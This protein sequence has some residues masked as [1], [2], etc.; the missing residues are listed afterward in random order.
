MAL[1]G[2]WQGPELSCTARHPASCSET[3]TLPPAA[4]AH[5]S[6]GAAAADFLVLSERASVTSEM[7]L[8]SGELCGTGS[9]P[10]LALQTRY[11][12]ERLRREKAAEIDAI[13]TFK[14]R[15]R[16]RP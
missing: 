12:L 11:D 9:E 6:R 13:P 2:R 4:V 3:R 5:P 8:R 1:C 14:P 15:D 16:T 7:R 10:R